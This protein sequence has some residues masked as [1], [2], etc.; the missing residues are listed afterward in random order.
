M[1]AA[2]FASVLGLFLTSGC[3]G[4]SPSPSIADLYTQPEASSPGDA[5]GGDDLVECIPDCEGK[6]CG[7]D[8]CGG[9]CGSCPEGTHCDPKF[10]CTSGVCTPGQIKC[11]GNGLSV[12]VTAGEPTWSPPT[13]CPDGTICKDGEC[14]EP[15]KVCDPG[16][17]KCDGENLALCTADGTAWGAAVPCPYG[18][19]CDG[20]KCKQVAA[21]TC[22]GILD[23]MTKIT[24]G[25]ADASC[26]ATCFDGAPTAAVEDAMGVYSC[27][28]VACGKWG[29]GEACFQNSTISTCAGPVATCKAG[30]CEPNCAGKQCG[31][32]GC[33]GSCGDCP[34]GTACS[35]AGTCSCKPACGGKECGPDGCGGSCG[36]CQ[37]G[38]SC[39]NGECKGG[40][41]CNGIP[42]EGCCQNET[43]Y[44]CQQGK[45]LTESCTFS[46][47]CGW[48]TSKGYY[49]CGTAGK[50]DPSGTFPKNCTGECVPNCAGKVCGPNGCGGECG[51]C[52]GGFYCSDAQTCVQQNEGSSCGQVVNCLLNCG[53][54]QQCY[55]D[56]YN[57]GDEQGKDLFSKLYQCITNECGMMLTDQC[58]M[59]AIADE[60][61]ASYNTCMAD[62]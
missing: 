61:T 53:W 8:N 32:N 28:F 30:T 11:D 22:G 7:P 12:C 50:S 20:G 34:A 35:E 1:K 62:Q 52:P 36:D 47:V 40:D 29:P 15:P 43:L 54:N 55:F 14:K 26:V 38:S 21:T 39:V 46:P 4:S 31:D 56:C 41:A 6:A 59:Q 24:C 23:C 44:Y 27:M 42:Y 17:S 19:K 5:D 60:C 33:G 3:S 58:I 51:T 45:L 10:E 49:D 9:V 57:S 48:N 2:L 16:E 37:P 25:L 13:P 18:Q